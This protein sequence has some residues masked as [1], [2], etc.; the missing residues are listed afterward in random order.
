MVE[1]IFLLLYDPP[2]TDLEEINLYLYHWL[3]PVR[4][5]DCPLSSISALY[6]R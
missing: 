6:S 3:N 2:S 5:G 4:K 1:A